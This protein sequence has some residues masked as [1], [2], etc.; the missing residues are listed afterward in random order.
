M[1]GRVKYIGINMRMVRDRRFFQ[2]GLDPVTSSITMISY[3]NIQKL[4]IACP[5]ITG[6]VGQ[7]Y[8]SDSRDSVNVV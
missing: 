3:G 6:Y 1:L 8:K 5:S 2:E 4:V 7:Y